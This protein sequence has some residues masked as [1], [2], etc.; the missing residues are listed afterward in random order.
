[1]VNGGDHHNRTIRNGVGIASRGLAAGHSVD[2]RALAAKRDHLP[3]VEKRSHPLLGNGPLELGIGVFVGREQ[4][5]PYDG[6]VLGVDDF[7]RPPRFTLKPDDLDSDGNSVF[8]HRPGQA[9][10]HDFG[11][12]LGH[13]LAPKVARF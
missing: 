5:V 13:F 4:F 8:R 3:A 7:E 9:R 11:I 6:R 1:M 2:G 12:A 10:F